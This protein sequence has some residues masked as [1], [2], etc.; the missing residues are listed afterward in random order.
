MWEALRVTDEKTGE[1]K[2]LLEVLQGGRGDKVD[3]DEN[4]K[5]FNFSTGSQQS[6]LAAQHYS[7]GYN[8]YKFYIDE[9]G[10]A[11]D[12]HL[13][14]DNHGR[15]IVDPKLPK[16]VREKFLKRLR[17]TFDMGQYY[18]NREVRSW[19]KGQTIKDTVVETKPTEQFMFSQ[20][21][22]DMKDVMYARRDIDVIRHAYRDDDGQEVLIGMS[23][24]IAAW[25]FA[26][27]LWKHRRWGS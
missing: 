4:I 6:M 15:L 17:Y 27:E 3:L 9:N 16:F 11:F 23:R 10:F 12:E 2:T 21:I 19:R 26:M 25:T 20:K 7:N 18:Y 22:L 14:R 8:L 1:E 24:N 13:K 5:A